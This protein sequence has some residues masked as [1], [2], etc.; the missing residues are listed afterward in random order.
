MTFPAPQEKPARR[1]NY[2][3]RQ[4][5]AIKAGAV[6][7]KPR[8]R[9][10]AVAKK[11]APRMKEYS[12]WIKIAMHGVN[13]C[14]RCHYHKGLEP[15]HA[16]GRNAENLFK[17]V[18]LCRLCHAWCHEFSNIAYALGWLQPEYKRVHRQPHH[19]QPFTLLPY[20]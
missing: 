16:F 10:K 4:R 6:E 5:K 13:R 12:E 9:I 8:Q 17:V 18:P 7:R 19:P 3:E 15:H 2:Q 14:A 1:L 20:P 11:N